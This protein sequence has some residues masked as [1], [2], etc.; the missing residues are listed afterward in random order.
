MS[1]RS[2]ESHIGEKFKAFGSNYIK[3]SKPRRKK[4]DTVHAERER[5][6]RLIVD[7]VGKCLVVQCSY[8][9]RFFVFRWPWINYWPRSREKIL[10]QIQWTCS[11]PSKRPGW[12]HQVAERKSGRAHL[13]NAVR[14]ATICFANGLS[15]IRFEHQIDSRTMK[16]SSWN[17]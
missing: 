12:V 16:T 6:L 15:K 7:T 11:K 10:V 9:R 1:F 8:F 5:V 3:S 2:C 14:S 13:G 4:T 17:K